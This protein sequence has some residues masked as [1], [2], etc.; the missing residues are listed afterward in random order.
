MGSDTQTQELPTLIRTKLQHPRLPSDLIPRPRLLDRLH[1]ASDRKL[2]LISA[3]AGAGK[4]TLL[5][6]WLEECPQPSAWLSLDE[7]DND[8][9]VFLTY[10][11]GAIR[12]AFP[13][14]CDQALS[15]LHAPQTPSARAITALIVNELDGLSADHSQE[16]GRSAMRP[17]NGLILALDDYHHITNPAIHEIL[18]GLIG[19]L[20]RGVHLAL[21]TRTDPPLP[22]AGW[23]ARRDMVEI[24]SYDLRFSSEETHA[25]LEGT[26]GRQL[27]PETVRLLEDRTEGWVVGLRLATLSMGTRTDARA[28]VQ[29]FKG[30]NDNL[31]VTSGYWK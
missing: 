14:G 15:L 31:I 12:A 8:R 22:L 11:C 17:Q 3:M 28:F 27:D 5:A 24:R 9:I 18:S 7:H 13:A 4:T 6:Q 29:A 10:L 26:T 19:H 16:G 21:A 30:T 1:A 25:F 23:R 20:P 2:I